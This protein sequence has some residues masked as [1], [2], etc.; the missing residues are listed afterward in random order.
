MVAR[1]LRAAVSILCVAGAFASAA[2][3]QVFRQSD[4]A[5]TPLPQPV[6]MNEMNLV[7]Q[8]WAYNTKTQVN[9]RMRPAPTS[10]SRTNTTVTTS[11]TFVDGDAITLQ[12]LFKFRG[13]QLDPV[14]DAKTG[15]GYFSPAC[16]FA[17][18]LLLRGGDCEVSF[19]WYNV[20]D[21]N[22]KDA[23]GSDRDLS[24]HSAGCSSTITADLQCQAPLNNGFCP[25]AWDAGDPRE[26]NK[27]LWVPKLYDSGSIK[28]DPHYKG[29]TYV[30][31]CGDR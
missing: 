11:P 15:P 20:D 9:K 24:V 3:A 8:S 16:G 13:E 27:K 6:G 4:A 19:G 28:K 12:G 1:K 29:K 18:Q 25:L 30:E 22:S 21:P 10:A 14:K 23:A 17:G 2:S 26:L 5:K 31:V 7:T